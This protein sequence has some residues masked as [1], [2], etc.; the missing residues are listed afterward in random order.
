MRRYSTYN[1]AFDNP[2]RYIDPDGMAPE[3]WILFTDEYGDELVQWVSSIDS[4]EKA[5]R[6][7]AYKTKKERVTNFQYLGKKQLLYCKKE[8]LH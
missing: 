3:D 4:K 8:S 6:W 5:D 2:L 7:A 1:Y